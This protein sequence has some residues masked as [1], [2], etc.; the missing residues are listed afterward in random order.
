MGRGVIVMEPVLMPARGAFI[1]ADTS[2]CRGLMES[3]YEK[4][5]NQ[6]KGKLLCEKL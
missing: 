6:L 3:F 1:W 4:I 5:N 2:L